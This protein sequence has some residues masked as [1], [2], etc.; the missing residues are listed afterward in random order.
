VNPGWLLTL[1]L[2]MM[3]LMVATIAVLFIRA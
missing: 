2:Y 3:G 1:T